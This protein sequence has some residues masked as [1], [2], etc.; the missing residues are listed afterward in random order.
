MNAW[1]V[2]VSFAAL[3]FYFVTVVNVARTR[4][5]HGIAPPAMTGHEQVERALRVQGNTVE[6]LVIFLPSLWLSAVYWPGPII[7]AIGLV[8][9]FGR[10]LYMNGYMKEP[11]ARFAGFGIQTLVC[12]VL[13]VAGVVGA[14]KALL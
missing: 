8:W 6:W 4:G 13:A 10:I 3:A 7:A 2:L 14:V 11:K 12:A 1:V 5:K 9:I